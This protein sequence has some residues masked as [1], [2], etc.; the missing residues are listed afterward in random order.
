MDK[1]NNR[2]HENNCIQIKL[3]PEYINKTKNMEYT[4][5]QITKYIIKKKQLINKS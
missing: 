4:T 2:I 3:R 5:K 1:T